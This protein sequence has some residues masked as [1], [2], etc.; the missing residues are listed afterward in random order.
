MGFRGTLTS[1]RARHTLGAASGPS[2]ESF[3][4]GPAGRGVVGPAPQSQ[5]GHSDLQGTSVSKLPPHPGPHRPPTPQLHLTIGIQR[6]QVCSVQ[7]FHSQ[8]LLSCLIMAADTQATKPVLLQRPLQKR[9]VSRVWL[10]MGP[11]VDTNCPTCLSL[12]K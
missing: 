11:C 5:R 7:H 9:S 8:P 3:D 4:F 2:P 1:G 12:S 10:W 6:E